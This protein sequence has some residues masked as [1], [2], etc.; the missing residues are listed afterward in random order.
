MRSSVL[1][2]AQS[3]QLMRESTIVGTVSDLHFLVTADCYSSL[4]MRQPWPSRAD[5]DIK[6]QARA[7]MSQTLDNRTFSK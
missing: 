3:R 2:A 4:Q 6:P 7:K 1:E 5:A